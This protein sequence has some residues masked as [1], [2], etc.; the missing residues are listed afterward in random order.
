MH[1]LFY[2]TTEKNNTCVQRPWTQ[3]HRNTRNSHFRKYCTGTTHV[4]HVHIWLKDKYFKPQVWTSVQCPLHRN[5]S[6]CVLDHSRCAISLSRSVNSPHTDCGTAGTRVV[7]RFCLI[8]L[9]ES[10]WVILRRMSGAQLGWGGS[11]GGWVGLPLPSQTTATP[12]GWSKRSWNLKVCV[13]SGK[14]RHVLLIRKQFL[15]SGR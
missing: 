10:V 13:F 14:Q 15:C 4:L 11:A 5:T 8:K 9:C 2:Y 3:I 7:F 12:T 1:L 6:V